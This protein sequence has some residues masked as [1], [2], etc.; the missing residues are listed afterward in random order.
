[1][2]ERIQR[3]IRYN[4]MYVGRPPWDTGV[5]P[6][7]VMS[8]LNSHDPGRALDMGCGTGTNLVTMAKHGWQVVGIDIAWLSILRAKIKLWQTGIKCRVIY[9]DVTTDLGFTDKFDLVLDIGCYHS[10]YPKG[11]ACYRANLRKWL[12]KGGAYLLYAHLRTLP[13]SHHGLIDQDV[14]AFTTFLDLCWRVDNVEN[15][16]DGGGGR[17]AAWMEFT[18]T[19]A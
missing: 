9:G 14:Q 2:F 5:S 17:P 3:W 6:P 15:R 19:V 8:F 4:L 11:R 16:P 10:L 1:M 18:R 13:E 7:E 12:K